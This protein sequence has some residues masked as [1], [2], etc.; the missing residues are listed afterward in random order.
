MKCSVCNHIRRMRIVALLAVF[1]CFGLGGWD[2]VRGHYGWVIIAVAFGVLNLR[3]FVR[4]SERLREH[5]T[6][7]YAA[8]AAMVEGLQVSE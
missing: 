6:H 2:V 1:L 8:H 3:L 5:R 4:Q 7:P